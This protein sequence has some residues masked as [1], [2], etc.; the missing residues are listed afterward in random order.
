LPLF[1]VPT[2]IVFSIGREIEIRNEIYGGRKSVGHSHGWGLHGD[3][4]KGS[5][6]FAESGDSEEDCKGKEGS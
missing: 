3:S 6:R 1:D 4:R 5:R 2:V